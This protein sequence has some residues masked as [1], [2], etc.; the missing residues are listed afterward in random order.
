[1]LKYKTIL[2]DKWSVYGIWKKEMLKTESEVKFR[3]AN[4]L[5]ILPLSIIFHQQSSLTFGLSS[6]PSFFLLLLFYWYSKHGVS[7][8]IH[9]AS[10]KLLCRF[11]IP[12]ICCLRCTHLTCPPVSSPQWNLHLAWLLMFFLSI[13]LLSVIFSRFFFIFAPYL[14]VYDQKKIPI[15]KGK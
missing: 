14:V 7:I 2:R 6:H 8:S 9:P 11:R 10:C 5:R 13:H 4:T 1:M 3:E 12:Q 15:K